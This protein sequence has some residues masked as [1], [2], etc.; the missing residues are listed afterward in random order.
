MRM[1]QSV[2]Q[3]ALETQG[4]CSWYEARP[5]GRLLTMV[6]KQIMDIGQIPQ[7]QTLVGIALEKQVH[8]GD[9]EDVRGQRAGTGG[10]G[11]GGGRGAIIR[12]GWI[13]KKGEKRRNWTTRYC[14]LKDNG[15][16]GYYKQ[17]KDVSLGKPKGLVFLNNATVCESS[18]KAFCFTITTPGRVYVMTA[19]E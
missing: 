4:A 5:E 6:A 10:G 15:Q 12:E 7:A 9:E 17:K 3:W 11:G 18:H 8:Q 13:Q 1:M 19:V 2:E 16:L 14:V